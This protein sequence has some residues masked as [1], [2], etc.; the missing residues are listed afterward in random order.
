MRAVRGGGSTHTECVHAPKNLALP[1]VIHS[2]EIALLG[3]RRLRSMLA[4]ALVLF[5]LAV[6]IVSKNHTYA[7][8]TPRAYGRLRVNQ[9][10]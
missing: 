6:V 4:A 1:R 2:G 9:I 7:T 10:K 3:S 5:V 8:P